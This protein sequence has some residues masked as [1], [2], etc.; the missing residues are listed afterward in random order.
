M[1]T[2]QIGGN[3]VDDFGHSYK[4][5]PMTTEKFLNVLHCFVVDGGESFPVKPQAILPDVS[6]FNVSLLLQT[7]T[8][9]LPNVSV[10]WAHRFTSSVFLSHVWNLCILWARINTF[11][12]NTAPSHITFPTSHPSYSFY[13]GCFCN[14]SPVW[15]SIPLYAY[16]AS[17]LTHLYVVLFYVCS[18]FLTTLS[19][20]IHCPPFPTVFFLCPIP[21][22]FFFSC[23]SIPKL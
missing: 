17:P 3:G 20:E 14:L 15:S 4:V 8:C 5:V 7:C 19:L 10:T 2:Y 18:L 6:A 9:I 13:L 21:S 12:L 23:I 16:S 1:Q 22:F 11:F